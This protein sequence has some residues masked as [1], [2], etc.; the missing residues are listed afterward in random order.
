[1]Q[2]LIDNGARCFSSCAISIKKV[3]YGN[4]FDRKLQKM[5][6]S[7]EKITNFAPE[8]IKEML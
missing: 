6:F 8:I 2:A 5:L 4:F 3:L 1:M 7:I